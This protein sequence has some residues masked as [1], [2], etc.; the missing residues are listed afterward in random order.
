[1]LLV[2][3][4]VGRTSPALIAGLLT[5]VA[6]AFGLSLPNVMNATMRPLPEIAGAVGA[7]A[8]SIQMTSGAISSG[9]VSVFF[10]GQSALSMTTVMAVSSLLAL[11]TYLLVVRPAERRLRF[12]VTEPIRPVASPTHP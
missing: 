2:L 6:L 9:M 4:L 1:M 7:A 11:T 10:D 8:G 5:A 3:V 12:E